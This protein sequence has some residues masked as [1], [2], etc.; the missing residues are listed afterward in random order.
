MKPLNDL[1]SRILFD[2]S[3]FHSED[4]FPEKLKN[5]SIEILRKCGGVP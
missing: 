2:R 3:I 4:A 5:A 1:D